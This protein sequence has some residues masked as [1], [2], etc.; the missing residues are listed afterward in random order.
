MLL[1]RRYAH[2]SDKHLQPYA[3]RPTF[4]PQ[5]TPPAVSLVGG[6]QTKLRHRPTPKG[7]R[8]RL[9]LVS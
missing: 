9:R 8:P 2:M 6:S 1:V 4:A 7:G 3:D 5:V